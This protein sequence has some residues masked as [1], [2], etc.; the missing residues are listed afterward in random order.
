MDD[1]QLQVEQCNPGCADENSSP[2]NITPA[3]T[4]MSNADVKDG[5]YPQFST[6]TD[7]LNNEFDPSFSQNVVMN[8]A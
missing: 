6:P 7:I 3:W 2:S 4:K 1:L 5:A 8:N